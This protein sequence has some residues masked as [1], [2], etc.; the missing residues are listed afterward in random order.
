MVNTYRLDS[1]DA[2]QA[3]RLHSHD[4]WRACFSPASRSTT[5]A[6]FVPPECAFEYLGRLS[7]NPQAPGEALG[8]MWRYLFAV[9]AVSDRVL[10]DDANDD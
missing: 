8:L 7:T 4:T 6:Y 9:F 5:S 1:D 2:T 10:G 3:G